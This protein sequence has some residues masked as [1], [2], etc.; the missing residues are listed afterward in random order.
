MHVAA[1]TKEKDKKINTGLLLHHN[2]IATLL[3]GWDVWEPSHLGLLPCLWLG[4]IFKSS[5]TIL[6]KK[7]QNKQT[8]QNK[9]RKKKNGR[10][11]D[12]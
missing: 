8:K 9:A 4:P 2:F 6:K 3:C 5:Q 7:I 11:T 10:Q 12:T 1:H